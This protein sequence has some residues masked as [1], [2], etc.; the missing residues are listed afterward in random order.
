MKKGLYIMA[1][2]ANGFHVQFIME[3]MAH[4][5]NPFLIT[6]KIQSGK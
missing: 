2:M 3:K 1:K 6:A 5:I 4:G